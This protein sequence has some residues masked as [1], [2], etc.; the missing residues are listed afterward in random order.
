MHAV[1]GAIANTLAGG[2][3]R[4]VAA[5]VNADSMTG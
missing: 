1:D 3:L 5:V 2:D 4:E